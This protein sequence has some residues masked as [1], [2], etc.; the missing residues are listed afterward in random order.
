MNEKRW[1]LL[2]T[3]F[4]Q[5]TMKSVKITFYTFKRL[6]FVFL[7]TF[8]LFTCVCGFAGCKQEICL[9]DYV[10][11]YR[12]NLFIHNDKGIT[13]KAQ[14]VQKEYP[15]VADGHKGDMSQRVEFFI[16]TPAEIEKCTVVFMVNGKEYGGDASYNNVKQQFYF[17]CNGDFA[18]A[19]NILVKLTLNET[20]SEF[21]LT[22]VATNVLSL[23]QVLNSVFE[24][25]KDLLK[26]LQNKKEFLGELYVRLLYE[27]APYF[28]VGVVDRNGKITAFL[29]DGKTGKILAKRTV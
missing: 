22:S 26:R 28:Y 9:S 24:Q 15:Y 6:I 18:G 12:N 21:L 25:E 23:E 11:E 8:F 16:T 20:E 19:S 13:I 29:L 1:Y 14:S 4:I 5:F 2:G 3:F 17:S 7:S 10:S 27:D